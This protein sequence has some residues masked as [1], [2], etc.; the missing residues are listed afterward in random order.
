MLCL[1][2]DGDRGTSG[3]LLLLHTRRQDLSAEGEEQSE[4]YKCVRFC[5]VLRGQFL[6]K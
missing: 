1:L 5:V 2:V 3:P 4:N 6:W